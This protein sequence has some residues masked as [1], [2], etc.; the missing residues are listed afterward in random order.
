MKNKLLSTIFL[1]FTCFTII[2][3]GTQTKIEKKAELNE[4]KN[5]SMTIKKGTLTKTSATIIITDLNKK[6]HDYGAPFRIDKKENNS[7][8]EVEKI[9]DGNFNLK[10]YNVDK[11]NKLE[12]ETN[13]ENIYGELKSGEYRMVKD[14]CANE[15][16]CTEKKYFSV[17][18]T[19]D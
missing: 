16:N 5:V 3:C 11:N 15:D 2:G 14:I 1:V 17:E 19:I 6:T 12:M 9:K 18:F 10:A 13:W 8:S 7:W 4:V